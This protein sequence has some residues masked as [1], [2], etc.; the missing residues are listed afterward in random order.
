MSYNFIKDQVGIQNTPTLYTQILIPAE[1]TLRFVLKVFSVLRRWRARYSVPSG[2]LGHTVVQ[3]LTPDVAFLTVRLCLLAGTPFWMFPPK[4]EQECE[5]PFYGDDWWLITQPK[6]I[7]IKASPGL[8]RPSRT[9]ST[10]GLTSSTPRVRTH[11]LDPTP[12]APR[13]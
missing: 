11:T 5:E 10:S 6:P 9:D 7:W 2:C 1:A 3:N 13:P 12:D 4:C 8:Q